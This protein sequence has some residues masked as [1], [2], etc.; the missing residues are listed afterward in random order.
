[1]ACHSLD[2][3]QRALQL[4]VSNLEQAAESV[5]GMQE[6]RILCSFTLEGLC[7][8]G[9][10]AGVTQQTSVRPCCETHLDHCSQEL[11]ELVKSRVAAVRPL[12]SSRFTSCE[13]VSVGPGPTHN[14]LGP[15]LNAVQVDGET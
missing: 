12:R 4:L 15:L 11:Y 13:S 8:K 5:I 7:K 10:L 6:T 2:D 3:C 9:P 14:C 1:M